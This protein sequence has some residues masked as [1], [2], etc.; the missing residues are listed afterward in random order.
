M[1]E[2][3]VV[4]AVIAILVSLLMPA[5]QQARGA[6]RRT[7]CRNNL[8]NVALAVLQT[9]EVQGRFPASA[10]YGWDP[11]TNITFNGYSWVVS[12]LPHLDQANLADKWRKEKPTNDPINETLAH[13]Y[14]PILTCPDDPSIVGMGD[15]SFVV[16]GGLGFSAKPGQFGDCPIDPFGGN[17]LDL[18]GNGITCASLQDDTG[19]PTDRQMFKHFG[20]FFLNALTPVEEKR[21]HNLASITDGVTHT[22][23]LSENVRVGFNPSRPNDSHWGMVLAYQHS[24]FIGNPCANHDCTNGDIDYARSNAGAAAINSG[25]NSPE[26][27]SPVPN[28]FHPGGVNMAFCDGRVQFLSEKIDGAVYAAQASPQ[29][30]RLNGTRFAQPLVTDD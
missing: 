20:V 19:N 23:M 13:T 1:I 5:I 15:L 12:I 28:S 4:M 14:L 24:F 27:S 6:A 8:R 3:V 16:S 26:G 11:A 17:A 22:Y 25:L 29:G 9:T 2:L 21:S 10:V 18:N 7:Q 30:G